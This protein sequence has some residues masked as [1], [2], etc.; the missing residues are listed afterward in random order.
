MSHME[1]GAMWLF[2]LCLFLCCFVLCAAPKIPYTATAAGDAGGSSAAPAA[3]ASTA[4]AAV[5]GAAWAVRGRWQNAA[6]PA[7]VQRSAVGKAKFSTAST[8]KAA[9]TTITSAAHE[10]QPPLRAQGAASPSGPENLDAGSES[11]DSEVA[12]SVFDSDDGQDDSDCEDLSDAESVD[13]GENSDVDELDDCKKHDNDVAA[14]RD[15]TGKLWSRAQFP[16]G[17]RGPKNDCIANLTAAQQWEC[18][19]PDRNCLSADR[20]DILQLYEYRKKYREVVAPNGG[21][22]RDSCRRELEEHYDERTGS[23]TR[24][25]RVGPAA[26]CCAPAAGLAKG[27]SFATW[28]TARADVAKKAPW[29]AARN[30]NRHAIES[31]ERAQLRAYIRDEMSAMEGPKGG[32]DPVDKVSTPYLSIKKRWQEYCEEQRRHALPIVGSESLFSKLWKSSGIR[33]E[34]SVGHAKCDTCGKLQADLDACK[35]RTD[36][37]GKRQYERV[38]A[39]KAAHKAAHRGERDFGEDFW[40]KAKKHPQLVT[41]MS[42]DAP[43]E[44]QFDVPV[45][46]RNA[47]DVVKALDGAKRWSSKITGM[48]CLHSTPLHVS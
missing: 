4:I 33:E 13:S 10:L 38:Q 23:F 24:S 40:R 11:Y 5:V 39:K 30:A 16:E 21:G 36:E 3:A 35:G 47:R 22:L 37:E 1:V 7:E 15:G 12:E 44:K 17:C 48:P 27:L 45:Q 46:Q 28:S 34:K 31:Q 32:S 26:D 29:R 9:A 42:M 8:K 18:P 43:T 2:W 19:C 14:S 6:V 20:I 41:A 25:F